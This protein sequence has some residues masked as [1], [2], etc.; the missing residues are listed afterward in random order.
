MYAYNSPTGGTFSFSESIVGQSAD[1]FAFD[2]ERNCRAMVETIY[3]VS[4][5]QGVPKSNA[6]NLI[7]GYYAAFYAANALLAA[8]GRRILFL[9]PNALSALQ[10]IYN[11]YVPGVSGPSGGTY[12]CRLAGSSVDLI[13]RFGSAWRSHKGLWRTTAEYLQIVA[14]RLIGQ[15]P[16]GSPISAL[17]LEVDELRKCLSQSNGGQQDTLSRI[18]NDVTY[19]H[20][21]GAWYPYSN[22]MTSSS[23]LRRLSSWENGKFDVNDL[24]SSDQITRFAT[25]CAFL[26][27]ICY[28]LMLEVNS[29]RQEAKCI[30]TDGALRLALQLRAVAVQH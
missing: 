3:S 25:A 22:A 29:R 20:L 7:K 21:F 28:E 12:E 14:N 10:T 24:A 30:F 15:A 13:E 5:V 17:G 9:D 4:R 23:L 6:W 2:C 26:V 27:C 16:V 1:A 19:R 18:R 8:T 11:L